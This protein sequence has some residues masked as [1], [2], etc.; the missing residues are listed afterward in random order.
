LPSDRL[1][2]LIGDAFARLP[3]GAPRWLVSYGEGYRAD[4]VEQLYRDA[5]VHGGYVNGVFY[6]TYPARPDYYEKHGL[7]P[8]TYADNGKVTARGHYW[9]DDTSKPFFV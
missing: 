5:L 2:K 3:K 7:E 9:I 1:N 4:L 8:S 6:S